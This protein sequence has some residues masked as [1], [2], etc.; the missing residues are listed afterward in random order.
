[1]TAMRPAVA[2]SI[3]ARASN[4]SKVPGGDE[5]EL[6]AIGAAISAIGEW[7]DRESQT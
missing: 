4:T 1:M 6:S 3:V 2:P 5:I 7:L